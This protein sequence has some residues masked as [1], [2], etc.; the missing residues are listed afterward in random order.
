MKE[1]NGIEFKPPGRQIMPQRDPGELQGQ[2][3]EAEAEG[4]AGCWSGVGLRT[5]P[6]SRP[7]ALA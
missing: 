6:C 3:A 1:A 2:L 5:A 4:Q 7:G